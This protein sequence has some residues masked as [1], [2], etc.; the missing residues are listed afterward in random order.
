MLQ[1]VHGAARLRGI[2]TSAACSAL[3]LAYEHFK[4]TTPS[5]LASDT[6]SVVICHGLYGSKQ[7]WRSMARAMARD[8]GVPI[9]TL[10]LRNH[11]ESPH[12]ETMAGGKVVMSVALDPELEDARVSGMI[13]VDISP[14]VGDISTEFITYTK[15]MIEIDDA[16]VTTRTEADDMLKD[17]EEDEVVRQFLLTN[18]VRSDD[19]TLRFRNPLRYMLPQLEGIGSFPYA[20][21]DDQTPAERTFTKPSLFVKGEKSKYINSR[22]IRPAERFFPDFKLVKMDTGHW[23]QAEKPHEFKGII[24]SFLEK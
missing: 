22:N 5:R 2:H 1:L 19:G 6:S 4:P 14:A 8:Y 7:N 12:S 3:K 11:G 17:V 13:S 18:L 9:Y 23:C 16:R 24:R 20:P 21:G 10:D 15:R